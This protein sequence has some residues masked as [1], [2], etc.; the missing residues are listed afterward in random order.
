MKTLGS[1][2][3]RALTLQT[4]SVKEVLALLVTFHPAL[5]ALHALPCDAPQQPFAFVAVGGRGGRPDL[6]VVWGSGR[7]GVD[8]CLQRLLENMHFL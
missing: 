2:A 5:Q 3:A 7:N 8:Q 4:V 1:S 6:K